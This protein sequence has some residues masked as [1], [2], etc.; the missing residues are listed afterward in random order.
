MLGE[1]KQAASTQSVKHPTEGVHVGLGGSP[2]E[3]QTDGRMLV[4]KGFQEVVVFELMSIS[5]GK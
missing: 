4:R 1:R 3:G 2:K 5:K